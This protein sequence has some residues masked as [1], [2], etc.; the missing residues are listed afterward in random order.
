MSDLNPSVAPASDPQTVRRDL[1]VSSATVFAVPLLALAG[2]L[3]VAWTA[4]VEDTCG[5]PVPGCSSLRN[6]GDIPVTV[7]AVIDKSDTETLVEGGERVLLGDW[8]NGVRVDHEQCLVVE[9]GPFW[10][11]LTVIDRTTETTGVWHPV[12]DWGA[13]LHLHDGACPEPS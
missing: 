10:D 11:A 4:G 5:G 1:R 3:V 13:R 2:I 12:D 9:G 8:R 7:R 6:A